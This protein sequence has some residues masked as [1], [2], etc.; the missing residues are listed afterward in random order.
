MLVVIHVFSSL[1]LFQCDFRV[2]MLI[3]VNV[4]YI[5]SR[6]ILIQYRDN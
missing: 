2:C 5:E 1:Y 3:S 6:T 4:K